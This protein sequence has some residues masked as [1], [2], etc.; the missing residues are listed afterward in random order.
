ME[1]C[2]Q[3]EKKADEER[4]IHLL[5]D[6]IKFGNEADEHHRQAMRNDQQARK[7]IKRQ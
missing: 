7:P 5:Y 2:R 1:Q 6:Q 4:S 3:A